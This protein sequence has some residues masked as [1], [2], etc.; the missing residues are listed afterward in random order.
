MAAPA[1]PATGAPAGMQNHVIIR[2]SIRDQLSLLRREI[3][4]HAAAT[5][6]LADLREAVRSHELQKTLMVSLILAFLWGIQTSLSSLS[7]QLLHAIL[8][9]QHSHPP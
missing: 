1:L 6:S 9:R 8:Q 7:S 3:E 4:D 2:E 5:M